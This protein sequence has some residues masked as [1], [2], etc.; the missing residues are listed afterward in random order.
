MKGG[1]RPPFSLLF[2]FIELCE[3]GSQDGV[4][5]IDVPENGLID[6]G[7][8]RS[9]AVFCPLVTFL[10]EFKA[11]TESLELLSGEHGVFPHETR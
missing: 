3:F 4:D 2:D 11:V 10:A 6:E 7:E 9:L 1:F 8:L 5:I